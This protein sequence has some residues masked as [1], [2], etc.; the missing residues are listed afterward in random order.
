MVGGLMRPILGV[1]LC[2]V[3]IVQ[4]LMVL[5]KFPLSSLFACVSRFFCLT[6]RCT[7]LCTELV[8]VVEWNLELCNQLIISLHLCCYGIWFLAAYQWQGRIKKKKNLWQGKYYE[9]EFCCRCQRFMDTCVRFQFLM[10]FNVWKF[11]CRVLS[12]YCM[13]TLSVLPRINPWIEDQRAA[14]SGRFRTRMELW[15]Y[16]TV[17]R[18]EP[19]IPILREA[20]SLKI[21]PQLDSSHGKPTVWKPS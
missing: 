13:K 7:S 2:L 14:V 21:V 19:G 12:G 8:R 4:C 15:C 3:G 18:M 20:K 16:S 17:P 6:R 5:I 1:V 11:R 9:F 10:W